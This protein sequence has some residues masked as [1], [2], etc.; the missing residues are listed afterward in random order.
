[1]PSVARWRCARL[2]IRCAPWSRALS[3]YSLIGTKRAGCSLSLFPRLP[4][5]WCCFKID[6]FNYRGMRQY[7]CTH[8][9]LQPDSEPQWSAEHRPVTKITHPSALPTFPDRSPSDIWTLTMCYLFP[10][11][12]SS[13]STVLPIWDPS[14]SPKDSQ[15]WLGHHLSVNLSFLVKHAFTHRRLIKLLSYR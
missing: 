9:G 5:A 4:S 1:M 12:L 3:L 11:Y 14:L 13:L 8:S 6:R 2:H 15:T 7:P 10:L